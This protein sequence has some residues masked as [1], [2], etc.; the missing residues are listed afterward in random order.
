MYLVF[1]LRGG[2]GPT[3]PR[4]EMSVAAGGRIKQSIVKDKY[5]EFWLSGR[6]TVFNT[7]ILNSV[8]Y[9]AVTGEAPPT[10]PIDA[11]TY[12]AHGF[13]FFQLYEELSGISGNFSKV[14]SVAE[15]DGSADNVVTSRVVDIGSQVP[16]GLV[17]P[18]SPLR[19]FRT[20]K[21][22]K[23]EYDGYHVVKF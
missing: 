14:K 10:K 18:N 3:P 21:D 16:V 20:A 22:L 6:T 11:K 13:P 9:K 1:R 12:K 15:L 4:H 7:Q 23:R 19:E 17:N 5:G 8:V 2:G